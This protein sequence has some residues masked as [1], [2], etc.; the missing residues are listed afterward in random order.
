MPAPSLLQMARKMCIKIVKR[1][2]DI[3]LARYE[4]IRPILLKIENPEQLH[5]LE[6]KS[7]HLLDHTAE[8]WIEFIKRDIPQ[9][10]EIELPENPESWYNVYHE[11]L[12]KAAKDIDED[13]ERMKRA[14]MGLDSKKAQH[15]SKVV[16]ARKL[17]LPNEKPT[18]IQKYAF[19]D[20]MMGGL[21]PIF[22]SAATTPGDAPP[23]WMIQ[24]PKLPRPT[25]RKPAI[26]VWKR[27]RRLFTPTHRLQSNASQIVRAPR[28]LIEDYKRPAEPSLPQVPARTLSAPSSTSIPD[29]SS[30]RVGIIASRPKSSLAKPQPKPSPK[31]LSPPSPATSPPSLA[32][33]KQTPSF[34]KPPQAAFSPSINPYASPPEEPRARNPSKQPLSNVPS[35]SLTPDSE[36][37][38][39]P[40]PP[41][42]RKRAR[43]EDA[44]VMKPKRP[45]M[46]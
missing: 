9:W 10:N 4:L 35:L 40:L 2:D 29:R 46:T 6:L 44:L 24:K 30:S 15:G 16:D 5:T 26:P 20:R 37:K 11:L 42:I 22:V 7:P 1:I 3:G 12:A 17:R 18:A 45:R 36:V 13:A 8:L 38:R 31:N 19:H 34:R 32:A 25:A 21:S 41:I 23:R 28:S 14:L 43:P 27:N 33:I 39:P